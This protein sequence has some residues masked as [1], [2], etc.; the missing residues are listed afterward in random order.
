MYEN[1]VSPLDVFIPSEGK[2]AGEVITAVEQ[3]TAEHNRKLA[4]ANKR[5]PTNQEIQDEYYQLRSELTK[6][7]ERAAYAETTVNRAAA[8]VRFFEGRLKTLKE[9]CT[10]ADFAAK[11][12]KSAF[13]N[14]AV[15]LMVGVEEDLATAVSFF[16]RMKAIGVDTAKTLKAFNVARLQELKPIVEKQDQAYS[17]IHGTDRTKGW[18]RW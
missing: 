4:E 3:T 9:S 1:I 8:R 11:K 18:G 14:P 10:E 17:F 16:D 7:Q 2:T 13:Y 15:N 6:R 5:L 12:S